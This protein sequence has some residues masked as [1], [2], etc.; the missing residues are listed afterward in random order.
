MLASGATEESVEDDVLNAD[1]MGSDQKDFKPMK[2]SFYHI[3]EN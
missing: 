1:K 3:R 2:R